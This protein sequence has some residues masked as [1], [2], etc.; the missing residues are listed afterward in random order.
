MTGE[1]IAIKI[2]EK[3]RIKKDDDLMRIRREM[4]ILKKVNH[5]NIIKLYEVK[6]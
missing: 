5:P 6:I 1:K 2:L 3:S 4:S